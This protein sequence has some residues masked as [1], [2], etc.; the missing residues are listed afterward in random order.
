MKSHLVSRAYSRALSTLVEAHVDEYRELPRPRPAKQEYSR[1]VLKHLYPVEWAER[2]A[3]AKLDVED[4][5]ERCR[6]FGALEH[7]DQSLARKA[8][9]QPEVNPWLIAW[10]DRREA[11]TG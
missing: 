6:L 9:E 1:T 5:E 2:Y 4:E 3:Q 10:Y 8:D 11:A 7:V